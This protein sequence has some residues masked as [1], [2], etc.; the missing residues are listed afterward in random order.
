LEQRPPETQDPKET[1]HVVHDYP[2]LEFNPEEFAHFIEDFDLSDAEKREY[3]DMIWSIIVSFVDLGFGI[4]PVQQACGKRTDN[5]LK[6]ALTAPNE[7]YSTCSK[8]IE[9]TPKKGG[10]P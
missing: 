7:I 4:H 8:F 3:L 1:E 2:A 9:T 6:S 5:L 10:A